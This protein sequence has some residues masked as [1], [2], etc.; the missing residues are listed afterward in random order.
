MDNSEVV[1]FR[2]S[3]ESTLKP[4]YVMYVAKRDINSE[5]ERLNIELVEKQMKEVGL[6]VPLV[7]FDKYTILNKQKEIEER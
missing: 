6:N 5:T 7:I 1:L 4:S 3:Y 2:N